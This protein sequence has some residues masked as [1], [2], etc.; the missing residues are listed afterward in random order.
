ME[1][2]VQEFLD[3]VSNKSTKKGYRYGLKKFIDWFGKSGEEILSHR[4]EDLT[5]RPQENLIDYKNRAIRF[6]KEIEK[7]H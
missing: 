1:L 7:F 2:S 6:E 5:Q 3:S 4:K